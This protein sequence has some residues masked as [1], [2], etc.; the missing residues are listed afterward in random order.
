MSKG[1]TKKI[2]NINGLEGVFSSRVMRAR[3]YTP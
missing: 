1:L 3:D 2:L